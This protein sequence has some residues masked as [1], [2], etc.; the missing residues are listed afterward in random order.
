[1]V[2]LIRLK[3]D[4]DKLLFN[5]NIQS[6]LIIKPNSKIALQNVSFKKSVEE[7]TVDSTNN[8]IEYNNGNANVTVNLTESIYDNTDFK[9]LITD[10]NKKLNQSLNSTNK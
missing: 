5:N 9:N 2:K 3:S 1:M 8:K 10:M 7:I 4:Q 6:D